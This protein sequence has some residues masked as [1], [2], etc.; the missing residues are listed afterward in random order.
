VAAARIP[1]FD[2]AR[3]AAITCVI[4]CHCGIITCVVWRI[5]PPLV[6][7]LS[8][9]FGVELFFVLSGYLIGSILIEIRA[10]GGGIRAGTVFLARRWMRTLPAY[11]AVVL[12]LAPFGTVAVSGRQLF[13]YLT[14]TQNFA[15]A[16]TAPDFFPVSWSLAIEEWFYILFGFVLITMARR[17]RLFALVWIGL[18]LVVPLIIRCEVPAS[19]SWDDDIRK[20]VCTRLDA[21]LYGGLAIDLVRRKLPARARLACGM[22]GA[23]IIV[24]LGLYW[25]D[26]IGTWTITQQ[27]L[28]SMVFSITGLAFALNFPWLGAMR[29]L[30]RVAGALIG[31][32]SLRSYSLYL[33]HLPILDLVFQIGDRPYGLRIAVWAATLAATPVL[34]EILYRAVERPFMRIRPSQGLPLGKPLEVRLG[35]SR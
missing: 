7:S 18:F 26:D 22:S 10:A 23:A 20:V 30:G 15:G 32:L 31:W 27:P 1:G 33:V 2:A 16:M 25:I 8:G 35:M 29:P 6:L 11:Y 14:L 3:A 24:L 5:R 12:I 19:A 28:R 21:I 34:T 17:G 9:Y 13:D 4:I